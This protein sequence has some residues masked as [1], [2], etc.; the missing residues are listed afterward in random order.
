MDPEAINTLAT[1][2]IDVSK[3]LLPSELTDDSVVK[4]GNPSPLNSSPSKL[5]A[6]Q[7][8]STGRLL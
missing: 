3:V 4:S 8:F 6:D 7:Y 1:H 2:A 5:S